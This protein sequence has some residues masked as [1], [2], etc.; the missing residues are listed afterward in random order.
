MKSATNVFE[1]REIAYASPTKAS[2]IL[3]DLTFNEI[4]G[5]AASGAVRTFRTRAGLLRIHIEDLAKVA[6][7]RPQPSDRA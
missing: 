5:I 2:R 6:A 7:G 4:L 1:H 3:P